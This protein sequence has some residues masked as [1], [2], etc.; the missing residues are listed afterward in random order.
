MTPNGVTRVNRL[1]RVRYAAPRHS[2][3]AK[4]TGTTE[5]RLS[6]PLQSNVPSDSIEIAPL[7]DDTKDDGP[8]D[9][10]ALRPKA[11]HVVPSQ[12]YAP[13]QRT[14]FRAIW[15][16]LHTAAAARSFGVVSEAQFQ[17]TLKI[18]SDRLEAVCS[19]CHR[20]FVTQVPTLARTPPEEIE[21][22]M[23]SLHDSTTVQPSPS[24]DEIKLTH[25]GR[26]A[27]IVIRGIVRP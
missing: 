13:V 27:D 11:T 23:Y 3:P 22:A 25:R 17:L 15:K 6:T 8:S 9:K 21:M 1:R 16:M 24:F 26:I 14:K 2:V 7:R 19:A 20:E 5:A 10:T 12:K 18:A 4:Q